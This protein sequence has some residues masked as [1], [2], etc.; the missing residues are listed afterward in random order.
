M[1][2]QLRRKLDIQW[3]RIPKGSESGFTLTEMMIVVAIIGLLGTIIA[4][5]LMGRLDEAKKETA[6]VHIRQISAALDDFRRVCGAYPSTE[7]GLDALSKLPS[8]VEC[9][10]YDPEGFMKKVPQDPWGKPYMYE[11]DGQKFKIS[12]FGSDRQAGGT[13]NAADIS[14]DD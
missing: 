14:S 13:G 6:K 4:K 9:P 7:Q 11:S 3:K 2:S 5:N 8:G 10:N 1:L 12:S